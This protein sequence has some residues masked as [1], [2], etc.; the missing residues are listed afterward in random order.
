M[1][2]RKSEVAKLI[3]DGLGN[4]EIGAQLGLSDNTV[5]AYLTQIYAELG[6]STRLQLALYWREKGRIENEVTE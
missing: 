1:T 4:K 5:K 2:R 6:L 3:S